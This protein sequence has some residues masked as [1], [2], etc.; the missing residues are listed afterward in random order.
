[1]GLFAIAALAFGCGGKDKKSTTGAEDPMKNSAPEALA[2]PKVDPDL[3]NPDGKRIATYDLNRDNK[4]DV[5][6][7][8]RAT[9][10]A[11]TTVEVITCTQYDYNYDGKKD[12]IAL[13]ADTGEIIAEEFDF[14]FE[15]SID[16]RY[17]YDR[18][19][20]KLYLVERDSDH[21]SEPD[22]WEE[23]NDSGVVVSVRLDRNGD[24]RPDVWEAYEDGVLVS[25]MYDDDF[26][27]QID[28]KDVRPT[29][30]EGP[31][32]PE[33]GPEKAKEEAAGDSEGVPDETPATDDDADADDESGDDAPPQ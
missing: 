31:K 8:S 29:A 12:Y 24:Q 19:T 25:I 2:V 16:S 28:R 32:A 23:Y 18:K 17:H 26:D 9:D 13:Y 21:D 11:G 30:K 22:I 4:P 15:G 14:T 5:W 7:I 27:N 3:C 33:P 10:Q 20:G 6:K 1:M